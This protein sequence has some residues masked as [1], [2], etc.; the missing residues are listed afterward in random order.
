MAATPPG[1]ARSRWARD[2]HL[3][4]DPEKDR[5][6]YL[7]ILQ[8]GAFVEFDLIGWTE[9]GTD[10]AR[11]DRIAALVEMGLR[12]SCTCGGKIGPL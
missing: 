6:Y 11:A 5:A 1:C 2:T 12:K 4:D 10:D 8:R 9:L 3:H 7:P